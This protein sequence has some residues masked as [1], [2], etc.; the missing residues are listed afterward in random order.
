METAGEQDAPIAVVVVDP[1]GVVSG[2]SEGGLLLLGW[3][4]EEAVGRPVTDLLVDPPSGFPES[5]G[6]VPTPT[7]WWR[8][9][10][11]T[12]SAGPP[13]CSGS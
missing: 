13:T 7:A 1:D 12:P 2:W 3:T 8:A 6:T 4:A 9:A 5:G 10:S 11:A